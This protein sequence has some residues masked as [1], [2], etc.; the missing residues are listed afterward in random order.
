MSTNADIKGTVGRTAIGV[1]AM[2]LFAFGLVPLYDVICDI[3]GLNGKTGG[4]YEYAEADL[5]ADASRTIGIRFV[6]NN[7]A[8][9]PW[10]FGAN[11]SL[12]KINPGGVNEALFHAS[13]PTDRIMVA[14][15]IPSVSPGRAAAFFHKTQCFCFDQQVL[16]P[17]ESVE[18]PVRF[19]VDRA[20]PASVDSIT[21]SYTMYDIT[22][23]ASGRAALAE[24]RQQHVAARAETP[25]RDVGIVAAGG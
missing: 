13:N 16:M 24:Y 17:G 15:T 11:A 3:T 1:L 5:E 18:M 19:I 9:M 21:L 6:T 14:Q 10:G 2:F 22:E 8:G 20:L 23:Q 4:Q 25:E 12:M 7:N